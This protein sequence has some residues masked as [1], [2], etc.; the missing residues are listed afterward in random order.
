MIIEA[1]D[2]PNE[3]KFLYCFSF[4]VEVT[5]D[6]SNFSKSSGVL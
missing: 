2:Q 1:A 3:F 4:V 5:L 6:F